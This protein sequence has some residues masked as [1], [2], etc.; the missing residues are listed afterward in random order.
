VNRPHQD[1]QS[2]GRSTLLRVTEGLK[3]HGDLRVRVQN[4]QKS[5]AGSLGYLECLISMG[6]HFRSAGK[7]G[8][9]RKKEIDPVVK[10]KLQDIPQVGGL[11]SADELREGE[12]PL[13]EG[14]LPYYT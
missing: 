5:L 3:I 6:K 7:R 9:I 2:V 1:Q 12:E 14:S 4:G 8:F 11:N 10:L 13:Y